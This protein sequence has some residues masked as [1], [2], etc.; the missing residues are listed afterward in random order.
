M[1]FTYQMPLN[2]ENSEKRDV[3]TNHLINFI[4]CL[5]SKTQLIIGRQLSVDSMTVDKYRPQRPLITTA[6]HSLALIGGLFTTY[7]QSLDS[8]SLFGDILSQKQSL[9]ENMGLDSLAIGVVS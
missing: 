5:R 4:C 1:L 3:F 6:D 8:R 9:Q 2:A 7:S